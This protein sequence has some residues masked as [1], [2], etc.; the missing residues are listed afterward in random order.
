MDICLI[1][2]RAVNG[3]AGEAETP[4]WRCDVHVRHFNELTLGHPVVMGRRTWEALP[5]ALP[6]R[7]N[8]VLSSQKLA[9]K[10]AAHCES[11]PEALTLAS[12]LKPT[13]VFV[14]GSAALH[15][16]TARIADR[17]YVARRGTD[18][19]D[20]DSLPSEIDWRQ[21]TLVQ[22]VVRNDA[23]GAP[24]VFEEYKR[25]RVLH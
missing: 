6:G 15:A 9:P 25:L 7:Q 3:A 19:A 20:I 10:G 13:K 1:W 24:L 14:I 16:K 4:P 22:R 23:G 11:L 5:A 12:V 17:L 21:F 18:P 2:S 8:I